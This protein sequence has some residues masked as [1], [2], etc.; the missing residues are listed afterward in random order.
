MNT[1]AL[2]QRVPVMSSVKSMGVY[3]ASKAG[4]EMLLKYAALEVS[5][6]S[7]VVSSE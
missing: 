6:L 1:S 2:A 7:F 5:H 3:A 4:A